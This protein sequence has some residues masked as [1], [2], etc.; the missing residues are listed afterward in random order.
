MHAP[1]AGSPANTRLAIVEA[2][3]AIGDSRATKA[4]LALLQDAAEI[5]RRYA[6]LAERFGLTL[7]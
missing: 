3:G 4:L 6:A 2:L 1:S 7:A 5:R